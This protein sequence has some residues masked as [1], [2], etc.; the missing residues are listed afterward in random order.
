MGL[1]ARARLAL[2][3]LRRVRAALGDASWRELQDEHAMRIVLAAA[4]RSDSNAIDVG[5]NVGG[6]LAE[7]ARIAPSGRHIAYEPIPELHG[8]LQERFPQIEV[9]RAALS[10]TSGQAEFA[11]VLGTP[12]YSGLRRRED[13]PAD[14]GEV[15]TISV[16]TERLD[17]TLP[18]GY[19]PAL[20]KIDVEGAE[21]SVLRGATE[22]LHRHRP[23][24]IFEHG[25]GGADLY[26]SRSSELFDLLDDCGLRIFDLTG[27]GPYSHD[28]F[29]AAFSEPIWNY[30][31]VPRA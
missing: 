15:R 20:L 22:T 5:A 3:R 23:Y 30:V 21:L 7:I 29:E 17:D 14:A 18:A 10:D 27:D 2:R 11:H 31:A 19:V 25:L 26:G 8:R 13:L 28:R 9:R 6:V 24:V 1:E 16:Q 12:A 4:L